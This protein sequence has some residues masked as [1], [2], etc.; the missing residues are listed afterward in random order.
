[1]G[2]QYRQWWKW[3]RVWMSWTCH[4]S[5]ENFSNL[6]L[7]AAFAKVEGNLFVIS[8]V[9]SQFESKCYFWCTVYV[10]YWSVNFSKSLNAVNEW[11]WFLRWFNEYMHFHLTLMI[12]NE[13]LFSFFIKFKRH[14][15]CHFIKSLYYDSRSFWRCVTRN[16]KEGSSRYVHKALCLLVR[17]K[18]RQHTGIGQEQRMNIKRFRRFW[19]IFLSELSDIYLTTS[20]LKELW[21]LPVVALIPCHICFFF[22]KLFTTLASNC[23]CFLDFRIHHEKIIS[24]LLKNSILECQNGNLEILR[25]I[26]SSD[27]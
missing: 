4:L 8:F 1:M 3:I 25:V 20:S 23:F 7:R 10:K 12:W 18:T 11:K 15:V 13:K 22:S 6:I 9:N 19:N 2:R 26:L 17:I 24:S 16:Q 14:N 21:H 5:L 27:K